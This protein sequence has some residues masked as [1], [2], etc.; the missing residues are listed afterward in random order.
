MESIDS[1]PPRFVVNYARTESN[2][3]LNSKVTVSVGARIMM[4]FQVIDNL[5]PIPGIVNY[6]YMHA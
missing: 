3:S 6:T 5:T 4:K 2:V 1:F